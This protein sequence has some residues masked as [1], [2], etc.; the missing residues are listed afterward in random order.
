MSGAGDN[1]FAIVLGP[2][3]LYQLTTV[4][5]SNKMMK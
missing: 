1:S 5:G 2:D 4:L 3:G